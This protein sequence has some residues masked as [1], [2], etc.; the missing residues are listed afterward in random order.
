M[1]DAGFVPLFVELLKDEE[2]L[3][4][5]SFSA[6]LLPSFSALVLPSFSALLLPS[7]SALLLSSFSAAALFTLFTLFALFTSLVAFHIDLLQCDRESC[8]K[9]CCGCA[10]EAR[11]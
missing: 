9:G 2:S 5:S 10:G 3:V 6:L 8:Y 4:L 11:H 1:V 7:F